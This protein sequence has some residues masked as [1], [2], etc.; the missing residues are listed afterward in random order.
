VA[1]QVASACSGQGRK[2]NAT[3]SF[4]SPIHRDR[5]GGSALLAL[6]FGQRGGGLGTISFPVS[7]QG[8]RKKQA[9]TS[10]S[11]TSTGGEGRGR[12]LL[13]H[14][15]CLLSFAN[16]EGRRKPIVLV[17]HQVQREKGKKKKLK[18]DPCEGGVDVCVFSQKE[19][20]PLRLGW[21]AAASHKGRGKAGGQ[22]LTLVRIRCACRGKKKEGGS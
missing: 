2:G 19:R 18:N 4:L 14:G 3:C 12:R 17:H 1:G 6:S 22:E 21:R 7:H 8:E 11:I 15:L 10:L 9:F 5:I 13:L 20:G 16:A